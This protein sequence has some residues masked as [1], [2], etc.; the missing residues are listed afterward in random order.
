MENQ[1]AELFPQYIS[2]AWSMLKN[3]DFIH[4]SSTNKKMQTVYLDMVENKD[5]YTFILSQF[6]YE[7]I[8]GDG[9][10]HINAKLN[11]DQSYTAAMKVAMQ[12]YI[13]QL[14]S[15]QNTF[16]R[17]NEVIPGQSFSYHQ[18]E[19]CILNNQLL[20]SYI[21]NTYPS[22]DNDKEIIN[23]IVKDM[24]RR[25][26]LEA[27]DNGNIYTITPVF[28]YYSDFVKEAKRLQ[29]DEETQK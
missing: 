6:G 21:R 14:C 5:K 2:E 4:Q 12:A 3:F 26:V 10:I 16:V 1:Y 18:I 17:N 24:E 27:T 13:I 28:L 29:M 25:Q 20:L 19:S 7:L 15:M 9:F 23:K 8:Y 22:K 11:V